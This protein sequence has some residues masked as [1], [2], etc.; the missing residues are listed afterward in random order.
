MVVTGF[1]L[2]GADGCLESFMAKCGPDRYDWREE[3]VYRLV[4]REV[5]KRLR[6]LDADVS[7]V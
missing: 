5:C 6:V 2:V 3:G 4:A 1:G 7:F